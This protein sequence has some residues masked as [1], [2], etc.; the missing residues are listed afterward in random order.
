[1]R[2]NTVYFMSIQVD[3]TT[4]TTNKPPLYI[5]TPLHLLFCLLHL[6]KRNLN[7]L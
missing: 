2:K 3:L 7:T 1:M 6:G 4:D 5:T